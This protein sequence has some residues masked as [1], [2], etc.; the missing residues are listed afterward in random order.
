MC[1]INSMIDAFDNLC[2]D[3]MI[4]TETW[5]QYRTSHAED[6]KKL[7]EGYGISHSKR[8]RKT[9]GGGVPYSISIITCL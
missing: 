9:R 2:L 6:L 7:E 1:K 3:F 5:L 8:N 4:V